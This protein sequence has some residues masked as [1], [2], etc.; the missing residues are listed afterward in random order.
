MSGL[1]WDHTVF[2]DYELITK[3]D[4][5]WQRVKHLCSAISQSNMSSFLDVNLDLFQ[6]FVKYLNCNKFLIC[7]HDSY[8]FGL[9]FQH[10][11]PFCEVY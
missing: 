3:V 4:A 1:I 2:E 6:Y 11:N 10:K 7:A 5:S 8:M 9:S